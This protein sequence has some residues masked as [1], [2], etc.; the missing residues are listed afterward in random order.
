M[1][2]L[3]A[4]LNADG[5]FLLPVVVLGTLLA[6]CG[7]VVEALLFRSVLDLGRDLAVREQRLVAIGAL[8]L[9]ALVLAAVELP[10]TSSL[11]A[12]GRRLDARMRL[13]FFAKVPR[14]G[15][16]YFRSRLTSDIAERVHDLHRLRELPPLAGRVLRIAIEIAVTTAAIIWI[17]PRSVWPALALCATSLAVP[18][19][20]HPVLSE[21][22]L[23]MRTHA[24]R[25]RAT[26]W[27]RCS[28]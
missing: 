22:E 9:F 14:L 11:V 4:T 17:D 10:I 24:A 19:S 28:G 7:V 15:D 13:R 12:A 5:A 3:L 8:L 16:R 20:A 2:E 25:S 6:S 26:T 21:L 18:L 1:R 27:M 23:R